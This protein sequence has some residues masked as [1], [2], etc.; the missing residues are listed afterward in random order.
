MT[1]PKTLEELKLLKR[2][3][4]FTYK[5]LEDHIYADPRHHYWSGNAETAIKRLGQLVALG[6]D[7]SKVPVY[8]CIKDPLSSPTP[9]HHISD[10]KPRKEFRNNKSGGKWIYSIDPMLKTEKNSQ[11]TERCRDL[12]TSNREIQ[13]YYHGGDV[14]KPIHC[15]IDVQDGVHRLI[16]S[17]YWRGIWIANLAEQHHLVCWNKNSLQKEGEDPGKLASTIDFRGVTP[18]S[19]LALEDM[20]RTIFLSRVG[21]QLVHKKLHSDIDSYDTDELPWALRSVWNYND[22][23]GYLESFG[24]EPFPSYDDWIET[25]SLRYHGFPV[26]GKD[27][28]EAA[29]L[30]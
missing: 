13:R 3:K 24:H 15:T 4:P 14:E 21:H 12:R 22:F 20:M 16:D 25:L 18:K 9:Y 30:L 8:R 27:Y 5:G 26:G 28:L 29:S 6:H 2:L 19:R 10:F 23:T 1:A 11:K 17:Q 7:I